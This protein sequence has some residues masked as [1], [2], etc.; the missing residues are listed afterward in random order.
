[1]LNHNPS[2][3]RGM[4]P[5]LTDSDHSGLTERLRERQK[6]EQNQ[7]SKSRKELEVTMKLVI[8]AKT[9]I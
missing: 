4:V 3:A 8:V 2:Q 7:S 1:M 5:P 9:T 6:L